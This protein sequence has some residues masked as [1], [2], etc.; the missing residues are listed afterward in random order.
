MVDGNQMGID[1]AELGYV[2]YPFPDGFSIGYAQLDVFLGNSG[3]AE[4]FAPAQ[5]IVCTWAN[6]DPDTGQ[7]GALDSGPQS[8]AVM[9]R[10]TIAAHSAAPTGDEATQRVAPGIVTVDGKN[11]GQLQAYCFGGS[12]AYGQD[13]NGVAC[14]LTSPAPILNLSEEGLNWSENGILRIVDGLESEIATLRAQVDGAQELSFDQH[15]ALTEPRLLYAVGLDLAY[16]SFQ[17][18]PEIM[19]T[20]HYWDEYNVLARALQE[21]KQSSWWPEDTS[22]PSVLGKGI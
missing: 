21:A 2:F 18:L 6:G 9:G 20:E 5:V 13:G 14:R 12:L 19:R 1:S 15:L 7:A 3:Q 16:H 8:G 22:L 17:A 11:G 10:T 4:G